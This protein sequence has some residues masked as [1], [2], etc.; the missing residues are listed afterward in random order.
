MQDCNSVWTEWCAQRDRFARIGLAALAPLARRASLIASLA[1]GWVRSLRAPVG[2]PDR[3]AYIGQG[4]A[5][6]VRKLHAVISSAAWT[7]FVPRA[8][9]A[10][11][12]RTRGIAC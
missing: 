11:A 2:H 3:F 5:R 6:D 10:S 12:R 4:Q 1:S 9:V 8:V 7:G